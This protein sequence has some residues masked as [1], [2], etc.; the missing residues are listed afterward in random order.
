MNEHNVFDFKPWKGHQYT[1]FFTFESTEINILSCLICLLGKMTDS[2]YDWS[3][4]LS[5][6]LFANG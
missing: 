4:C 2:H 5:I 1:E 6:K 3:D